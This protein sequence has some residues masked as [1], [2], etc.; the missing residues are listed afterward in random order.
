MFRL[1]ADIQTPDMLHLPVPTLRGGKVQNIL[2]QASEYQKQMVASLGERAD[3]VR[4]GGVDPHEDNMLR[5]TN[6]GRLLAL[7]AR[8]IDPTLPDDPGSK[9]NTCVREALRIYGEGREQ[10]LTQMIFCDLSTPRAER[11]DGSFDDVYHD[12]R[13]KL[14]R[15]GIPEHEIAFI[16]DA[17]TEA[18]KD[19][20]FAKVRKGAVRILIGSTAK[21]GAGTN[22]QT[23]LKALH[24]LDCPWRPSDLQQRDGRILRQG[25]NNSEVEILRYITQ[26]TFDAYSYQLVENKQKFIS[27][28]FT[29]KSPMRGAEDLDETALSYAEVKALAA[30][31]P[32]IR[33]KMDLDVQ[34]ARLRLL[35]SNW[36]SERYRLEDRV[37]VE[38]PG[39]IKRLEHRCGQIQEDIRRYDMHRPSKEDGFLITLMG[40][41]LD[42]RPD[43]GERLMKL[44]E[45]TPLGEGMHAGSFYGFELHLKR[46]DMVGAATLQVSGAGT[47]AV[48]MGESALGNIQ[49]LENLLGGLET[50]W[51]EGM[52]RLENARTQLAGAKE[53]LQKAWPQEEELRNKA[54]RLAELNIELDVGGR[55]SGAAALDEIEAAEEKALPGKDR[56]GVAR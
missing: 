22:V 49:R 26:D 43:A 55:D 15:G 25:N 3:A 52:A 53:E 11:T 27:Q 44:A 19:A 51:K 47:Y 29:S 30:G 28:I 31:N 36:Q 48:E 16:H 38:L 17:N 41:P 7:D 5:I 35:K 56:D 46:G 40:Q 33:E 45:L 13:R 18:Q 42:K 20:L 37:Q 34:L 32:R 4:K 8:L 9:V 6:D 39:E 50:A 14:I 54:A 21:M 23:R 10:R 2:T 12:L 1:A 24:H